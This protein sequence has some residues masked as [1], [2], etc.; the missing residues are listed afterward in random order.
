MA[1]SGKLL[2][3]R[4]STRKLAGTFKKVSMKWARNTT[5]KKK[6]WNEKKWKMFHHTN[7]YLKTKNWNGGTEISTVMASKA[8]TANRKEKIANSMKRSSNSDGDGMMGN[9]TTYTN[10]YHYYIT[11]LACRSL[12]EC[13]CC[14]KHNQVYK[15]KFILNQIIKSK[16]TLMI[17]K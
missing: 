9:T 15:L 17:G 13:Y 3:R 16:R 12:F 6:A 14:W 10:A 7:V 2:N 4:E 5:Q 8:A 1:Q 11:I